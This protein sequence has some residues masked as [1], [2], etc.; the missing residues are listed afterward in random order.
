MSLTKLSIAYLAGVLTCAGAVIAAGG[1]AS[2]ACFAL[3]VFSSVVGAAIALGSVRRLHRAGRFLD[4]FAT[5]LEGRGATHPEPRAGAP[6][7][8]EADLTSAMV[9]MGQPKRKAAEA[10]RYV[11]EHFPQA[12]FDSG[13]RIAL[14]GREAA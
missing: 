10:A 9:N 6:A 3:G 8:L 13:F 14:A 5:A 12:D 11:V 2:I 1:R 4:A 7:G